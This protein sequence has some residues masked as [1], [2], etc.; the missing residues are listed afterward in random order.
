MKKIIAFLFALL[1]PL[2][3]SAETLRAQVGAPER[4]QK[5]FYSRSGKTLFLVDAVVDVPDA[6]QV[7]IY[8]VRT[9]QHTRE[10]IA[11]S[12]VAAFGNRPYNGSPEYTT[13][14][15]FHR[16]AS[17]PYDC[18]QYY[19]GYCSAETVDDLFFPL[20]KSEMTFITR[21]LPN[22]T[23]RS[24]RIDYNAVNTNLSSSQTFTRF[25]ATSFPRSADGAAPNGCAMTAAE[26]CS[27]SDAMTASI[28]PDL[29]F[30]AL[31]IISSQDTLNTGLSPAPEAWAVYYT[32]QYE[33]PYTFT[34][35]MYFPSLPDY[36]V[37]SYEECLK[38][39]INDEGVQALEYVSPYE[40]VGVVD[41]APERLPFERI[42]EVAEALLPLK[43]AYQDGYEGNYQVYVTR[44]SL[45]YMR[46]M[47][48][49]KPDQYLL[50]PVWD[51]FGYTQ[52]TT[53]GSIHQNWPGNSL[54]TINAI[55]GTVI[56]R[57][58]GY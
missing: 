31:G 56:D 54:L 37:E 32:R 42:W 26:A 21:I 30:A 2:C 51:F 27:Q 4:I 46:V 12:A 36:A 20:P 43:F 8:Q 1:L 34:S 23:V 29:A 58:Y 28:N 50:V 10:E 7:P 38:I 22:G 9:R 14:S 45:G 25:S 13:T 24:A 40:I 52:N 11:T 47:W 6:D 17:F 15:Q 55:D 33:L 5:S 39:V 18:T 16:S 41:P 48:K 19:G 35:G 49:D 3:A 44:I 53:R 57:L